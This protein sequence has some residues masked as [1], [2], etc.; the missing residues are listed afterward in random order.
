MQSNNKSSRITKL[1]RGEQIDRV[2]FISS[3]TMYCGRIMNLSSDEFYFDVEKSFKAQQTILRQIGCDGSPSYDLPNGEILDF[4]G[5]L[6]FS[7]SPAVTLPKPISP[8]TSISDAK[9]YRLPDINQGKNFKTKMAF[10]KYSKT[11]GA[12][13]FSINGG[14]P[15]TMLG[16]LIEPSL[17]LIWTR[18][19]QTLLNELMEI[20]KTYLLG[21]AKSIIKTFGVEKCSVTYNFPFESNAFLSPKVLENLALPHCIDLHRKFLNMG[22]RNFSLHF[23]GK[24]NKTLSYYRELFLPEK[25][26]ISADEE[27]DLKEVQKTFGEEHIYA[28]NVSSGLLVYGSA[29]EVYTASKNIIIQMKDN[30]GGFV[31]MPSCDLPINT[32]PENLSA[33]LRACIDFGTYQHFSL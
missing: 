22:I 3:A 29:K 15:F 18:K 9:K 23:C 4:G 24:H 32:N 7:I 2:P 19:E 16:S 8:I 13:S 33:M 14:S 20:I 26:F 17:M 31:L 10:L 6:D 12:E 25:A 21:F 28:G 27:T 11:Q 1:F 30:R 5:K